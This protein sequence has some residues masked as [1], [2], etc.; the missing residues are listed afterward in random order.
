MYL[1]NID[2]TLAPIT[3]EYKLEIFFDN[4]L[5][6]RSSPLSIYVN[7]CQ[8]TMESVL[9]VEREMNRNQR[10]VVDGCFEEGHYEQG[11]SF[12]DQLRTQNIRPSP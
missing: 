9:G 10:M 5:A 11:I 7:P 8:V 2:Q 4:L 6:G 1:T 12:L 3:V